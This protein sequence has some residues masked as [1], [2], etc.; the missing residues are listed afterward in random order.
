MLDILDRRSKMAKRTTYL[1]Q[2]KAG[3]WVVQRQGKKSPESKHR[4]KAMAV[5]KGRRLAKKA[6]PWGQLRIK[7]KN[8]RIQTEHTYGNDPR[9][10][11]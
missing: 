6:Q 7:G 2:T 3:A 11:G 9:G 8:G 1:V 10:G 5:K 4:T